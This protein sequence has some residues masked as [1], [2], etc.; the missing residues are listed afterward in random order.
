MKFKKGDLVVVAKGKDRTKSGKIEKMI[1]KKQ[2]AIV[3][4]VNLYKK[5]LKPGVRGNKEGGIIDIALP[6]KLANLRV[7]CAKC[8]K[9]TRVGFK[10][11]GGKK[12]R[13]CKKCGSDL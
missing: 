6:I 5:H 9:G 3:G 2:A 7:F 12:V 1:S 10:K 13:V 8:A 11:L 4:G